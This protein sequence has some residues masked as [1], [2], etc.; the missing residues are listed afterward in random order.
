MTETL[1]LQGNKGDYMG[2][3][4]K[5]EPNSGLSE[6]DLE[7]LARMR[8]IDDTFFSEALKGKNEAVQFILD[9][10]LE[11]SDLKVIRTESQY[12]Y[13]SAASRSIRLDIWAQDKDGK[14]ADIEVQC[15][16]E[17]D[18]I[19]RGRYYAG[20]IDSRLLP[21]GASFGEIPKRYVIFITRKDKLGKGLPLYHMRYTIEELD[22]KP[23][24]DGGMIVFVNGSFRDENHPV[25]RLMH[26]F[27]CTQADEM[28]SP[29]LAK[30]VRS[31]KETERG[32]V[33]M[34]ELME[35]MREEAAQESAKQR[36]YE[37]MD[38]MIEAG[39]LSDED[40][41]MYTNTTTEEVRERRNQKLSA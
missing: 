32:R 3:D 13:H 21:K 33:H 34:C 2:V 40:I 12:E 30:E 9:T 24:G 11:G 1:F 18:L 20:V 8:L 16:D 6:K 41:A 22:D 37:I 31:I 19:E 28:F 14:V 4:E 27:M 23:A 7:R 15:T 26:D 38:T 29:I 39:V 36:T 17:P 25:G 35:K 5:I 10:V